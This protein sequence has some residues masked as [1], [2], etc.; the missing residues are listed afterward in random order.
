MD[1]TYDI[2]FS[3]RCVNGLMLLSCGRIDECNK[4][5][6]AVAGADQ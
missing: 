6:N 1:V 3:K 2:F 4:Q 5:C